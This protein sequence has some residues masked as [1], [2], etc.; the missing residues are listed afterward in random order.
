MT[1][2]RIDPM[3]LYLAV[4]DPPITRGRSRR[5]ELD[6]AFEPYLPGGSQGMHRL[7]QNLQSGKV[8]GI[9]LRE[10]VADALDPGVS[11]ATPDRWPDRLRDQLE[12]QIPARSVNL[13]MGAAEPLPVRRAKSGLYYHAVAVL[14]LISI[15]ASLVIQQRITDAERAADR[16]RSQAREV[17]LAALGPA[18]AGS[19]QPPASLLLG[20][21]RKLRA[22]RSDRAGG[23]SSSERP[24]D[25]VLAALLGQWPENLQSR[26]ESLVV[27]PRSIE[28]VVTVPDLKSAEDFA[29]A[30]RGFE[31][32][33]VGNESTTRERDRV[34]VT[35]RLNRRLG[36]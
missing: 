19:R 20:E 9:A 27:A 6:H 11:V 36:S 12:P 15:A 14:G 33:T 2:A 29:N 25:R 21:L 34:R 17:R 26:T 28:L 7:Y 18:A 13:L 22:T 32:I 31:G 24:A 16:N 8:L 5:E 1:T 3:D 30:I 10:E 23:D 4:L 35:M